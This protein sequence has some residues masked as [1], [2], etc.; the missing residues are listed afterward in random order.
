MAST[1]CVHESSRTNAP[2]DTEAAVKFTDIFTTTMATYKIRYSILIFLL[3]HGRNLI[4]VFES[5]FTPHLARSLYR[6]DACKIFVKFIEVNIL[7]LSQC[8]TVENLIANDVKDTRLLRVAPLEGCKIALPMV[9]LGE[10]LTSNSLSLNSYEKRL[11]LKSSRVDLLGSVQHLKGIGKKGIKRYKLDKKISSR[12]DENCALPDTSS[13]MDL[14]ETGSSVSEKPAV[15]NNMEK[16]SSEQYSEPSRFP[17]RETVDRIRRGWN[18]EEANTITMGD[19]FLMVRDVTLI[20]EI[21]TTTY[22]ISMSC[23][24]SYVFIEIS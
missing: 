3:I 11:G 7:K 12:T 18:V 9:N 8:T 19:L 23:S 6:E 13:D 5:K 24:I 15:I 10:Y 1:S 16:S 4:I 2:T 21:I 20:L 22:V 17:G 14:L